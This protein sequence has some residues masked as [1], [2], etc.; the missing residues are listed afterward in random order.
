MWKL[1]SGLGD[2][3]PCQLLTRELFL[4]KPPIRRPASGCAY[5]MPPWILNPGQ[6]ELKMTFG[7]NPKPRHNP[8]CKRRGQGWFCLSGHPAPKVQKQTL[9]SPEWLWPRGYYAV[10]A[11]KGNPRAAS[12]APSRS[13]PLLDH[14]TQPAPG[15]CLFPNPRECGWQGGNKEG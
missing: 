13:L 9:S 1:V 8:E 12:P 10:G 15:L 3:F 14:P 11:L 6:R 2:P 7:K 4:S 5:K